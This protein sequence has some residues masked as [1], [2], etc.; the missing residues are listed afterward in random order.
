MVDISG[1]NPR[2]VEPLVQ[3]ESPLHYHPTPLPLVHEN[4][5]W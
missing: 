2:D 1:M 3:L 4:L 5:D